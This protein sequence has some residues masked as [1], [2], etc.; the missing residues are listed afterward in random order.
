MIT[1]SEFNPTA[2]ED[3]LFQEQMEEKRL[4]YGDDIP[5]S[6]DSNAKQ[7]A[8]KLEQKD[9]WWYDDIPF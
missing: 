8:L 9:D 5:L 1:E 2:E 4:K 6:V 7:L 3:E